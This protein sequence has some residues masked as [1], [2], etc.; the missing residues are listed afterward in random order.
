M[1]ETPAPQQ[2]LNSVCDLILISGEIEFAAPFVGV[3]TQVDV[4]Q[5]FMENDLLDSMTG[6]EDITK[7]PELW[8]AQE[9]NQQ[10]DITGFDFISQPY[11][12]LE[13]Q[14]NGRGTRNI[15]DDDIEILTREE[16]DALIVDLQ[17]VQKNHAGSREPITLATI[18]AIAGLASVAVDILSRPG[19]RRF[20]SNSWKFIKNIGPRL[21]NWRAGANRI[22]TSAKSLPKTLKNAS[23]R[24]AIFRQIASGAMDA[25]S[26]GMLL[27]SQVG[28]T[29]AQ[30]ATQL[31]M[32][33][34]ITNAVDMM[35]MFTPNVSSLYDSFVLLDDAVAAYKLEEAGKENDKKLP[36]NAAILQKEIDGEFMSV[37][38]VMSKIQKGEPLPP[39]ITEQMARGG[40]REA[41]KPETPKPT[42]PDTPS[43]KAVGVP[44][45]GSFSITDCLRYLCRELAIIE[46][47]FKVFNSRMAMDKDDIPK[48]LAGKEQTI[49]AKDIGMAEIL[50]R[51]LNT[52]G[53]KENAAGVAGPTEILTLA[54][55]FKQAFPVIEVVDAIT[56]KKST[57]SVFELIMKAQDAKVVELGPGFLKWYPDLDVLQSNSQVTTHDGD[58]Y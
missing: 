26:A 20:A 4:M 5:N 43:K 42:A 28:D 12:D 50:F 8:E 46:K 57:V 34:Q 11:A 13:V 25:S 36:D 38:Q 54:E 40:T 6:E 49:F 10:D 23:S 9:L 55:Q 45:A 31:Q 14:E 53:K 35:R 7:A 39:S 16:L 19:I 44:K 51:A 22:A 3:S 41:P 29:A 18:A 56:K 17:S 15:N 33:A 21:K 48:F 24:D 27:M 30:V 2:H 47:E 32:A 37:E 58:N 52:V 1:A